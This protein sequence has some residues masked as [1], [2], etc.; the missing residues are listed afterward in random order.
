MNKGEIS[1][2][3]SLK[4]FEYDGC[5]VRTVEK[6]GEAW[7]VGKDVAE[8]LGY[9]RTRDAIR[10]NVDAEDRITLSSLDERSN[11]APLN[12]LP[13]NIT[14]INEPGVY[15]LIFSSKLPSAKQFKRWVTHEVLPDIRKH[16][17][18]MSDKLQGIAKT[19]PEAFNALMD[20]YLE[21]KKKTRALENYIEEN[22]AYTNLGHLVLALPGSIPF[23][24]MIQL[25][26][27][28]GFDIGRNT[29]YKLFREL[30]LL[31]KQKNRK[32][33]PTQKGIEKG[34][35]N[36]ELDANGKVKFTMRTMVTPEGVSY[37]RKTLQAL[38]RP[39]ELLWE[40][41]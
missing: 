40:S 11:T 14:L 19:D 41:E 13:D 2:E 29:G 1:M 37:A 23:P 32:N 33:K 12:G 9:V 20:K 28:D 39:L 21:E 18:Y 31:S 38:Q 17:M 24:D 25:F 22:R 5:K 3:N 8:A 7:F 16:G 30:G 34:I 15:S 36:L 6:D 27:Q 26:I 10:E 35:V 4:I